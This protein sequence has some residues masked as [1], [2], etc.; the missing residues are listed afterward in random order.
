MG[1]QSFQVQRVA[2]VGSGTMG[3]GIAALLA[4][5]GIP[6]TILDITP[7]ELTQKEIKSG[8]TL[9]ASVVRNRIVC[10]NMLQLKNTR[11]PA[12]YSQGDMELISTGNLDDDFDE[13]AAVDWV[14]EAIIEDLD[15]KRAFFERLDVIRPEGQIVSSNTS[16]IPI[17][18]LA[19]ERSIDFRR[20]FLGTHFFNPPRYL[21]LMEIIPT[22]DTDPMLVKFFREFGAQRLGKG[23]VLCRDTPNFIA[24][25]IG[26]AS[27]GYR[28]SYAIENGYTVEEVD[29]IAGPLM[30]YPKTAVFRLLDLV[31]LDVAA[32][33]TANNQLALP[34]DGSGGSASGQAGEVMETMLERGWLGNKHNVGFYRRLDTT[35]GGK[36]FWPLDIDK[37][38][39]VPPRKVRFDSIDA[40][41]GIGDL[42]KRLQA[43][44]IQEDRAAQYVWHTLAFLFEYA[45]QCVLEIADELIAVDEAMRWGYMM[46]AGPFE[47]WDMLGV[48][49]TA[50]RM[51]VDGY[52][53]A[54]WVTEM[55]AAGHSSFYREVNGTKEQF[56]P[57]GG[58]Y[59][60]VTDMRTELHTPSLRDSGCELEGNAEAS[61]FDMGDGVLL[62][63]FHGKDNTLGMGVVELAQ[64]SIERLESNFDMVGMVIGN[65]GR[66]FSAGANLD[67]KT[68]MAGGGTPAASVDRVVRTFQDLLQAIR[69]CTKPIVAA[70]FDRTLGSGTEVVLAATRVVAH[71]ELY[72][73]LVEVGVGLVPAGGGCK[74][75][76]RRVMNPVMAIRN[77]DPVP[78]IEKIFK[79]IAM[80]KVSMGAVEAR[81]MGYLQPADRIVMDRQRLLNEAKNEVLYLVQSGYVP[82]RREK[83]YAG[84]R[85]MLAALRSSLFQ[86]GESRFISSHDQMIGEK[87][88]WILS[89]GDISTPEWV[90]EQYILDLE[91]AAF[92]ELIQTAKTMERVLHTLM[93]GKP[94]RN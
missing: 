26:S 38:E 54:P 93:T 79:T 27:N 12:L 34:G 58:E 77:A 9:E 44:I 51:S 80:A 47:Y 50:E 36:E 94:L 86:L 72:I 74:E 56:D 76:L 45:S 91:R 6:V 23:V 69:Y 33:V 16:G 85:D 78:V 17:S 75:M 64:A 49:E 84:G 28:M 40:V 32:L 46:D 39:H 2:V 63:E 53:V 65:E 8:L 1:L 18:E 87:L 66:M 25:R 19:V 37:M 13:L 73:G 5:V 57:Q 52:T 43:W 35:Q 41:R 92:V 15:A 48:S 31:G 81:E 71:I 89:G 21:R 90:E 10:E 20:C 14:I 83:I 88:S 42:G 68:L 3:G 82:P 24:N 11:P 55:L 22:A 4:G 60:T 30:G 59:V 70:P 62:L 61:L 67:P 29:T 7:N